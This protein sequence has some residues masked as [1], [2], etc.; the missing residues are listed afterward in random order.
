[1]KPVGTLT[2]YK[3]PILG[4][5]EPE[6]GEAVERPALD[7]QL[8]GCLL[9]RNGF[10]LPGMGGEAGIG[11]QSDCDHG[12]LAVGNN[13]QGLRLHHGASFMVSGAAWQTPET[14]SRSIRLLAIP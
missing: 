11:G 1:M 6:T 14:V 8:A 12:G 4:Q 3:D 9:R 7:G 5:T 13:D 2:E 10:G